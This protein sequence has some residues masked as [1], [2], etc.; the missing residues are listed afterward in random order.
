MFSGLS[1]A[2]MP[3]TSPE[4]IRRKTEARIAKREAAKAARAAAE[5]VHEMTD[6][7]AA[8][9]DYPHH[10][11]QATGGLPGM[12][13]SP[14]TVIPTAKFESVEPVIA[15]PAPVITAPVIR[16]GLPMCPYQVWLASPQGL[17]LRHLGGVNMDRLHHAYADRVEAI[18]KAG[19]AA[20][21]GDGI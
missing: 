17:K 5:S 1:V 18:F 21:V 7:S 9:P 14:D 10:E 13:S 19:Y 15:A 8:E 11:E 20:G 16:A 2:T 3:A 12:A 4:A 6:E